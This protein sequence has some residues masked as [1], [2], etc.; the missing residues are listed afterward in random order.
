MNTTEIA[1]V[2]TVGG[3]FASV[4]TSV[5][6]SGFRAGKVSQDIAYIRRDLD[7]LM[8]LFHLVP[9]SQDHKQ[10]R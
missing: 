7:L 1:L 6:I 4:V 5:F 9:I 10:G 2:I 8:S 3:F